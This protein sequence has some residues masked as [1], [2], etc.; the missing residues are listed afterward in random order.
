MDDDLITIAKDTRRATRDARAAISNLTAR[1]A[2]L[3]PPS[4][5]CHASRI[6][7]SRKEDFDVAPATKQPDGQITSDFRKTCQALK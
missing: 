1:R 5:T 4:E 7:S 2:R 3:C 6:D